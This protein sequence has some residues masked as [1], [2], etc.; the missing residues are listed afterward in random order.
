MQIKTMAG[1]TLLELMIAIGI[2]GILTSIAIPSYT[3]Y[4]AQSNR[5][6]AKSSL[7]QLAQLLERNYTE[8]GY[9]NK[10]STGTA[11]SASPPITNSPQSGTALYTLSWSLSYGTYT[12][13]ATPVTGTV[14]AK[15]SCGSFV[16]DNFGTKS[17]A[18]GGTNATASSCWAH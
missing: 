1:F 4:I 7:L 16:L 13:T 6:D 2:I 15:D 14:Q 18:S 8:A 12:L 3:G 5:T 9:Y 17:I 10:D 11:F